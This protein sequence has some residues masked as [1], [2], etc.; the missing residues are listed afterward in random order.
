MQ[1]LHGSRRGPAKLGA[2]GVPFPA[3][4]QT[5]KCP[6]FSLELS[7]HYYGFSAYA[8]CQLYINRH[9]WPYSPP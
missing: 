2:F 7:S 6:S 1:A 3:L 8:S 9:N 4:T 5:T